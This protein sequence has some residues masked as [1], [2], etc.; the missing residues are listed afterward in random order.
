MPRFNISEQQIL[1]LADNGRV[2]EKGFSYYTAGRVRNFIFFPDN[3]LVS[4]KCH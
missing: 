2:Y 3:G 4:A 1:D